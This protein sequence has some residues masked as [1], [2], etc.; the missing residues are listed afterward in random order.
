MNNVKFAVGALLGGVLYFL[1]GWLIYGILLM[2]QMATHIANPGGFRAAEE[3][4][5]PALI[6][7]NLF[8]GVLFAYIL[9]KAGVR[10]AKEGAVIGAV[11]G[12]LLSLAINLML[13]AQTNLYHLSA[14][15]L[16][17]VASVVLSGLVGAAIGWYFSR[18]PLNK[19]V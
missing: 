14:I 10:S 18:G 4:N 19:A 1:L 12:G 13:Y 6:V 9:M 5:F 2:D 15:P 7:G 11:I 17:L 3:M 8:F 16:D